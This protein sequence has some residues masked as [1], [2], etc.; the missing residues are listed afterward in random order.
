MHS[1]NCAP[2]GMMKS[3]YK[4][5]KKRGY[6]GHACKTSQWLSYCSSNQA[7][8]LAGESFDTYFSLA[9][10]YHPKLDAF[11]LQILVGLYL[12]A[13]VCRTNENNEEKRKF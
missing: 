6:P 12:H 1:T 3:L 2:M 4:L 5:A 10:S 7:V 9:T 11:L 13:E 8:S